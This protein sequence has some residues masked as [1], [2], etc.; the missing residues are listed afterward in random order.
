MKLHNN[1]TVFENSYRSDRHSLT[2]QRILALVLIIIPYL[3]IIFGLLAGT[4]LELS[5]SNII[6]GTGGYLPTMI[7]LVFLGLSYSLFKNNPR[8]RRASMLTFRSY[9]KSVMGLDEREKLVVDQAFRTSYRIVVLTCLLA[10]VCALI[11]VQIFHL[12]YQPRTV[13]ILYIMYGV[14]GLLTYLPLAVVAW[15]E[16]A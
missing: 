1:D 12:S 15:K 14:F 3:M 13:S 4:F 11:N 10:L 9:T 16:E 6:Y 8:L 7:I 5:S 2:S